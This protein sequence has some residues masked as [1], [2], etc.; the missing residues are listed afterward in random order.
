MRGISVG[1]DVGV[2]VRGMGAGA[3]RWEKWARN[4]NVDGGVVREDDVEIL[5]VWGGEM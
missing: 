2:L 4:V 1:R 3:D 5:C